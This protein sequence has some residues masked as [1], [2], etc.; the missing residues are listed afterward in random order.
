MPGRGAGL[1]R[2]DLTTLGLA[3]G[4]LRVVAG[5]VAQ[6]GAAQLAFQMA[7]VPGERVVFTFGVERK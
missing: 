6:F 1:W 7:G 3:P 4:S 2:V 5:E